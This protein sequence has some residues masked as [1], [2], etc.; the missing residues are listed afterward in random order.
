[1]AVEHLA[2]LSGRRTPSLDSVPEIRAIEGTHDEAMFRMAELLSDI[3]SHF[4]RCGRGIGMHTDTWKSIFQISQQAIL[5]PKIVSPGADAV[6]FI[7]GEKRHPAVFEKIEHALGAKPLGGHVQQLQF[8]C[9]HGVRNAATLVGW[10]RAVHRR[11]GN[12]AFC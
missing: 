10:L 9:P 6:R 7:D 11:C 4:V 3:A 2:H 5:G 12:P 1:M 8:S